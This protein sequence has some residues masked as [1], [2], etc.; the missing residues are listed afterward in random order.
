MMRL[1]RLAA[2]LLA[3]ALLLSGCGAGQAAADSAADEG[4]PESGLQVSVTPTGEAAGKRFLAIGLVNCDDVPHVLDSYPN[5]GVF[6]GNITISR[7]GNE[8]ESVT[9]DPGGALIAPL[10]WDTVP[11]ST[12][13][14]TLTVDRL[15]INALPEYQGYEVAVEPS[16]ELYVDQVLD[17]GAWQNP[18]EDA[19]PEPVETETPEPGPVETGECPETGFRITVSQGSAAMGLRTAG[20]ELVNCGEK[21][22][23]VNGYPVVGVPGDGALLDVEVH[24]GSDRITDPGPT[25]LTVEPGDS[26]SAGMLWRNKVESSD[27]ADVVNATRLVMTYA[28]GAPTVVVEPEATIDLGTTRYLEVTAWR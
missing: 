19:P 17:L 9:V 23:E 3:A 13:E 4:C 28:E 14:D 7:D 26:I 24:Q 8:P 11:E 22:I 25:P 20:I 10:A 2:P 12:D 15:L 16:F 18:A 27:P 1:P 21:A 6:G 5:V